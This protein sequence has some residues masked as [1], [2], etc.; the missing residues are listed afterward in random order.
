MDE[1]VSN[2]IFSKSIF[3]DESRLKRRAGKSGLTIN[4]EPNAKQRARSEL[5]NSGSSFCRHA[6][7]HG[8]ER[9]IYGLI[10]PWTH[11]QP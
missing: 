5:E 7:F 8:R 2:A 9:V 3:I 4:T 11:A 6:Q 10:V 1:V